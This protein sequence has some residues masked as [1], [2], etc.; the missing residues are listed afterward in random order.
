MSMSPKEELMKIRSLI[1]RRSWFRGIVAAA[2]VALS[3]QFAAP[4]R[5]ATTQVVPG[6]V[7]K[8]VARLQAL[9]RLPG[10]N[11]LDLAIGLPFRN[12]EA[13][14]NLLR[15]L[16]DPASP[17]YRHFLTP[18][19]F[20]AQFGPTEQDYQQ[21]A[22]FAR[23]NGLK[24]TGTYPN[25]MVLDVQGSVA[26]V[27][28]VFHVGLH[29]Y[30]HPTEARN[31]YAPDAEPSLNLSVPLLHID[32]LDNF[33]VP[34]PLLQ[35]MPINNAS[36]QA[37]ARAGSATNAVS[38]TGSGPGGAFLGHDFRKAYIPDVSLTGSGQTV[39][40][41]ELDG[42]YP[43][44]IAAYEALAG[45]PN[46]PLQN[47]LIDG[48]SGSPGGNNVEVALDIDM[49]VAM[50]PGVSQIIVY[51]GLNNGDPTIITHMLQHI[52]NDNSAAQISS[53]W[54]LEDNPTWT[55]IYQEFAGQGQSFFQAS[56]DNDAFVW[57]IVGQQRTDN[58]YITLVGG[59][60]LTTA[61][62]GGPWSSE[63]VWNWGV[64][65]GPSED[66]IGSGG[67][68]SPNYTIPSW[69]Q[70]ISMSANQ[71]STT[72]RN[73][74]DVALTADNIFIFADDG[75]QGSVGGT[76]A[77]APL[78]AGF[79]A[80]VNQQAVAG[81]N[82]TVGFINPAV[83]L[84][85]KGA[86]YAKD[87]RDTKTG[88]NT[89]S[90]STNQFY[91]TNGYD[92]CTGWGTP[93][94]QHL[95]NDLAGLPP[96]RGF[97]QI[98]VSPPSG[99]AL[100]QSSAQPIYVTVTDV[101][102][103]TN[104]TVT[105]TIPGV[106]NLTFLD[107]GQAPDATAGDGIYSVLFQVPTPTNPITM[108]VMANATNELGITNVI[109]Y[110]IVA[111]PP[112]DNFTNATKAPAA[113][114]TY[115]ANN[116]FATLEPNEPQ[117]DKDAN[118]GASLW[119]DWTP[120]SNTN[121]FLTTAGSLVDTV[122]AVYTGNTL[123]S[124]V[125]VAAT[126]SDLALNQPAWLRF[127]AQ[128]GTAY[129]IAVASANASV[130]GTVALQIAPGG[131]PDTNAPVVSIVSPLDGLTVT[132]SLILLAGTA[133]D[134]QPNASGV[135]QV[136]ISSQGV[137]VLASGTT[138]WTGIGF[139]TPGLNTIQVTAVDN[140]G[141]VSAPATIQLYY[142]VQN[143]VNDFFAA[144]LPLSAT[145]PVL[146]GFG[147][148][149]SV[150]NTNATKELGEPNHAGNTGG[151][152]VWW[153][154]QPPSDGVLELDTTNSTFDTLLGLYTG[155]VVSNLTTIADNDDAYPGAP[156]GFSRI[157][158]AVHSNLLYH[159]AVD[160]YGG[161]SGTV[162]LNYLF[163]PATL[164]HLT[165][166]NTV[167][168]SVQVMATNGLGGIM[169]L[170][171]LNG[172]FVGNTTVE[173]AAFPNANYQFDIWDGDWLSLDNP[174]FIVVNGNM[175]VTGHFHPIGVSDGFESGD[176]LQLPWATFGDAPWFVETNVVEAGQYAARSGVIT[177][178]QSSTLILTTNFYAGTGSFGYKVS[179]ETNFDVLDFSVDGFLVQEW[180]GE[181]GW[182]DF[183]FPLSAGT[184][185]LEWSYI[186]D[187]S[188]SEGLDA[189]FLDNVI[190]PL[191]VATNGASVP[192]LQIQRQTDGV[193]FLTLLGQTNQQ[194]VVQTSTNLFN[195]S[196][197]S[198]N[199]LFGGY[200]HIQLPGSATNS[201]QFYRA[202]LAP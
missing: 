68:I 112:N 193:P 24:V 108:T 128:G 93:A 33:N 132:N 4:G 82:P 129:R 40:L 198:T 166:S 55:Q 13:L 1:A 100:L 175:S 134:P 136:S 148:S 125:A 107:N 167:G 120:A 119:W 80:L 2:G 109:A 147:G 139:V 73:I 110:N 145:P 79:T 135:S 192:Q 173:L 59:T 86:G 170:P 185:T 49:V 18:A 37:P 154:F 62:P 69:Q 114:A 158:Q 23:A 30:Q 65:F 89:W 31:F 117:H 176:L 137:V 179:S 159:I 76:S 152:S 141:N 104:A 47:E 74:P 151:K 178:S 146:L 127:N 72:N 81:G 85:G 163:T 11:S 95:I 96:R 77:A 115:L 41:F 26:D 118:D 67:G 165:V 182:A 84:I 116:R 12:Q 70:G 45:L 106:T 99:S 189:A 171:S 71:G 9:G 88:N 164:Y 27:E 20:T 168:G 61:G 196:N 91:A 202:V 50:A 194:Y 25:R 143:P 39:A 153:W 42:Y 83:C 186:K 121:V 22:D 52:L 144:A 103:V 35:R 6:H 156:G 94:G 177:N 75:L 78:W 123:K 87:F 56:G 57:S 66:G 169:L 53:S 174:V 36:G 29:V 180:S 8:A 48:F 126:N 58:P 7:P 172:D 157:D 133:F 197:A 28:K 201:I 191:A 3:L 200:L 130:V 131:Q 34:R 15:Q 124:L 5:A 140:Y 162:V 190:L 181:A 150:S 51:E 63:T 92:L 105:A 155:S 38:Y 101:Y 102:A 46:V 97:L 161:A 122:L 14:N 195:W 138:N 160:G 142:Y 199:V 44:D 17:N 64:E 113:G 16:Y 10:T 149:D 19:Q 188:I 184:H 111:P 98:S 90:S 54:L 21:V 32:G 60:T 183:E 187:P 43:S